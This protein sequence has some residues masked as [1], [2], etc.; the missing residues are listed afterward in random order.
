MRNSNSPALL[1][2]TH[3]I[4]CSVVFIMFDWFDSF[5]WSAVQ[6]LGQEVWVNRQKEFSKRKAPYSY[7]HRAPRKPF[8]HS[9]PALSGYFHYG[10]CMGRVNPKPLTFSGT[11]ETKQAQSFYLFL[12]TV[13]T[14]AGKNHSLR[15]FFARNTNNRGFNYRKKSVPSKR[16]NR[17]NLSTLR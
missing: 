1:T 16:N 6:T 10:V 12:R 2:A 5:R 7:R 15:S 9:R 17:H 8:S 11:G 13:T 3:Q 14:C 4:W